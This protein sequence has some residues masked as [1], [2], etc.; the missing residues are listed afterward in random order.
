MY[1][2][3]YR[4]MKCGVILTDLIEDGGQNLDLFDKR[5]TRQEATLMAAL[6]K[7][8]AKMGQRTLFYA[9]SGIKRPWTGMATLKS[10]PYTT[11]WNC[12]PVMKA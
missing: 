9:G 2:P 1:K 7:I 4:Y 8:N 6:D 3:G 5:D 10:A 11:D 12:L